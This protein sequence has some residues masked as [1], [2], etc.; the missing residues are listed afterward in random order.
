MRYDFFVRDD[1]IRSGHARSIKVYTFFSTTTT[2]TLVIRVVYYVRASVFTFLYSCPQWY[3]YTAVASY[4]GIS[5]YY[6]DGLF[7]V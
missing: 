7:S 1:Y 4:G 2:T 6:S 3:T 5:F